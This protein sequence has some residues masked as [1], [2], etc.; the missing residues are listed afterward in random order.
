MTRNRDLEWVKQNLPT[1][2]DFI[3][4]VVD[5]WET[6]IRDF[7]AGEGI[8]ADDIQKTYGIRVHRMDGYKQTPKE[9][10]A[11]WRL[12]MRYDIGN[13]KALPKWLGDMYSIF[14]YQYTPNAPQNIED[15]R[16]KLKIWA[17]AYIQFP[18]GIRSQK[19]LDEFVTLNE[20][21][22]IAIMVDDAN[23]SFKSYIFE[24]R[25]DSE[26]DEPLAIPQYF[27]RNNIPRKRTNTQEKVDNSELFYQIFSTHN[28]PE[29]PQA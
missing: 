10:I 22:N 18:D 7:G 26:E 17:H 24:V 20:G 3:K 19:A 27:I 1:L 4:H 12:N 21:K 23:P 16:D 13:I 29:L 25:K 6:T 8:L 28:D 11:L 9:K 2:A 14:S 15:I 5:K